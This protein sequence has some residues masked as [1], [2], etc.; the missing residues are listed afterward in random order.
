MFIQHIF[1]TLIEHS[2]YN[3]INQNISTM[4]NQSMENMLLFLM[5][6]EISHQP[7]I[8]NIVEG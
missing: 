8:M 4:F 7:Q 2:S 6:I 1:H 5:D 3:E